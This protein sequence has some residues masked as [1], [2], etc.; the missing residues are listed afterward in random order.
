MRPATMRLVPYVHEDESFTVVDWKTGPAEVL[1]GVSE[2][3]APYGL[4]VI[5]ADTRDDSYRFKVE[6]VEVAR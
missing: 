4:R 1:E 2:L 3:L 6:K 5:L